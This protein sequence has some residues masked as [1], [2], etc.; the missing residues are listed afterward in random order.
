MHRA[1]YLLAR[2]SLPNVIMLMDSIASEA[3]VRSVGEVWSASSNR[4]AELRK[5]SEKSD[6]PGWIGPKEHYQA[7]ISET[8][9]GMIR[10]ST[11]AR[12]EKDRVHK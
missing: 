3:T 8:N 6:A 12:P 5:A 11:Y 10:P 2:S 4:W 1:M 7:S 9:I